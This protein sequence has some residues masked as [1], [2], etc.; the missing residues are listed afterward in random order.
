M[1]CLRTIRRSALALGA[2]A[3][4]TA[5]PMAAPE[6]G[7]ALN[8]APP[9]IIV[10]ER[11]PVVTSIPADAGERRRV[12]PRRGGAAAYERTSTMRIRANM[13][14]ASW[15]GDADEVLVRA[16]GADGRWS[17][18]TALV[19]EADEAPDPRAA[20][21]RPMRGRKLVANPVWVGDATAVQVRT[22]HGQRARDLDLVAINSTGTATAGD[23][24]ASR[25]RR[26]AAKV[27]GAAE[28]ARA[29]TRQPTIVMRS[30]WGADESIRR[31][32][33]TYADELEA[34]VVHH[35][36]NSNSYSRADAP[37]LVRGIYA[38]HVKSNGWNDIGYNFVIDR[39]GQVFEGRYG[40]VSSPVIGA[41]TAG[42]NT[43]TAGVALL[44]THGSTPVST[45]A[46][47]ALVSLLSWRMDQAHVNPSGSASLRSA[48]ND[49]FAAGRT[50]TTRAVGGH[51]DLFSTECPGSLAYGVI[52]SVRQEAWT[53][54]GPKFANPAASVQL[55]GAGVPTSATFSATG[56]QSLEYTVTVRRGSDGAV[57]YRT[58]H[59]GSELRA[60][61]DGSNP[62]GPVP[63]SQL[64]WTIEARA[65][66]VAATPFVRG[67]TKQSPP[68]AP[69]L[70]LRSGAVLSPNGDRLDDELRLALTLRGTAG[71]RAEALDEMG[72][73][74]RTLTSGQLAA[75]EHELRWNGRRA[76]GSTHD[77]AYTI[78]V[79]VD[80]PVAGRPDP[81]LAQAVRID[82]SIAFLPLQT[83]FSPNGDRKLDTA[84]V[85]VRAAAGVDVGVE[86]L[87]GGQV[88]RSLHDGALDSPGVWHFDGRDASGRAL[89]DGNYRVRVVAHLAW[90]DH[91][92][93]RPVR[94]DRTPPRVTRI[95]RR[96][97]QLSLRLN[98]RARVSAK[99]RR[100]RGWTRRTRW[101][102]RGTSTTRSFPG[103]SRLDVRD[104]WGNARTVRVR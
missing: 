97:T 68:P 31:A 57:A 5:A 2:G 82:R 79:L 65:G 23:R 54:G 67:F 7:A 60:T 96:G 20:E 18:W 33:P 32:A 93:L 56:N 71:V 42:F 100:G 102:P 76:D 91:T 34:A 9:T 39:F 50:V 95:K 63:A 81:T 77:G 75:G 69:K 104:A 21:S 52:D 48:G 14:G 84:R 36:V 8:A 55:N 4:A 103:A 86:I 22:H 74:V 62:L 11:V 45:E 80:D 40:G 44:G 19:A 24:F 101:L 85:R 78:R 26:S 28:P 53:T 89:R 1:F 46:R 15:T 88:Q 92:L 43:A 66:A 99:V 47:A 38:Y 3:L 37:A 87:R 73:V 51:R 83:A 72:A 64:E 41:H 29:A 98:E 70:A 59:T 90:G 30:D 25:A 13:L 94:L 6:L 10:H 16:R 35:T 58:T 49:K 61:W 17:R 27:L 12:S